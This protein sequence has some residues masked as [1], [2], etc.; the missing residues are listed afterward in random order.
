MFSSS[1]FSIQPLSKQLLASSFRAGDCIAQVDILFGD[2]NRMTCLP[3][4]HHIARYLAPGTFTNDDCLCLAPINGQ[5][6]VY[7]KLYQCGH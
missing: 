4:L 2:I 7:S 6:H 3:Y 1:H 5:T